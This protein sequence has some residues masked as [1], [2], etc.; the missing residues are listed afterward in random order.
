MRR[1]NIK[2]AKTDKELDRFLVDY[3]LDQILESAILYADNIDDKDLDRKDI[4][5]AKNS[6]ISVRDAWLKRK[7]N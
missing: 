6:L 7:V 4:D 3:S 1:I 5:K 2:E